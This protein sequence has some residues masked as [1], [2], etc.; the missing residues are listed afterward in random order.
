MKSAANHTLKRPSG[1]SCQRVGM[2]PVRAQ[3]W[4]TT[5]WKKVEQTVAFPDAVANALSGLSCESLMPEKERCLL[6]MAGGIRLL[7]EQPRN[8]APVTR[9][10]QRIRQ[11]FNAWF[12]IEANLP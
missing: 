8:Y 7:G 12:V 5:S 1:V 4:N 10:E 3:V 9:S 2:S 11:P 6:V